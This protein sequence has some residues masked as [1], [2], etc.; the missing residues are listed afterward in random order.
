MNNLYSI[1]LMIAVVA[2]IFLLMA[3]IDFL[4]VKW[5]FRRRYTSSKANRLPFF[6]VAL[7]AALAVSGCS[8]LHYKSTLIR[9][10]TPG[11]VKFGDVRTE[12][13]SEGVSPS[14][15]AQGAENVNL[16]K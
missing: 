2:V 9:V 10:Y 1:I 7:L 4:L 15:R 8:G 3:L 16:K 5:R 11:D 13:L 6:T 14:I 12:N